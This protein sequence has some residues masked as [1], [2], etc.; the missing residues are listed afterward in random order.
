MPAK[1]FVSDTV[2]TVASIFVDPNRFQLVPLL[3]ERK[4][5]P[6]VTPLLTVTSVVEK[7]Y[8]PPAP[9]GTT[10]KERTAKL[11]KPESIAVH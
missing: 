8:A 6:P 10:A 11:V 4:T 7:R 2:K 5:P 3:A 9:F 1:R